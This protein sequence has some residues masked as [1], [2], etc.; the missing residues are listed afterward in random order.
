MPS[1]FTAYGTEV[2]S[3]PI[4]Y[5]HDGGQS[6]NMSFFDGHVEKRRWTTV[7][8]NTEAWKVY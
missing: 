1:S 2:Q 8:N 3:G 7:V 4:P 6:I 5:R